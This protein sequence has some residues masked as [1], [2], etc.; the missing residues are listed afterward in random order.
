MV[1]LRL[2]SPNLLKYQKISQGPWWQSRN[3]WSHGLVGKKQWV[4]TCPAC[5]RDGPP[6]YKGPSKGYVEPKPWW[7]VLGT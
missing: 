2:A 7:W 6:K 4:N 3:I 5:S 1:N